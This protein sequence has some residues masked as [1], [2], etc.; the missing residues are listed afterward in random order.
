MGQ[1]TTLRDQTASPPL[2]AL[3]AALGCG[4][5]AFPAGFLAPALAAPLWAA[6]VVLGS[7]SPAGPLAALAAGLLPLPLSL[8]LVLAVAGVAAWLAAAAGEQRAQK[9]EQ[10]AFTDRLTGLYNYDFFC[11]SIGQELDRAQRYGANLTLLL[12]DV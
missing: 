1:R 4:V 12:L 7:A 8:R 9:L 5:S 3:A 11:E 2:I 10:R 6:P